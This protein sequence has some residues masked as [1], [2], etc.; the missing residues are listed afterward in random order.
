MFKLL[1]KLAL[2][3]C[4]TGMLF[5]S[6]TAFAQEEE[7]IINTSTLV[8]EEITDNT[9]INPGETIIVPY[10]AITDRPTI[11]NNQIGYFNNGDTGTYF[12]F[13]KNSIV[14]L[15]I[16]LNKMSSFEMGLV[17]VSRNTKATCL[18]LS[19]IFQNTTSTGN[20]RYCI[21][22]FDDYQVYLINYGASP[23]SI[24]EFEINL[25]Y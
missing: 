9:V 5:N 20:V 8:L 12:K 11:N 22:K 2:G 19:S 10:S 15:N 6:T 14:S 23:L 1:K 17:N 25:S 4:V 18:N 16:K 7:K 13:L 21:N 3:V 24:R